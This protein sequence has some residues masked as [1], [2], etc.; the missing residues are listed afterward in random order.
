MERPGYSVRIL[1]FWSLVINM[2][3]QAPKSG[4]LFAA[5]REKGSKYARNL[6]QAGAR[7][8][9]TGE[10]ETE[11]GEEAGAEGQQDPS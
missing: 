8:E 1:A 5:R 10:E 2:I 3:E 7:E 9:T 11:D 4:L 6:E